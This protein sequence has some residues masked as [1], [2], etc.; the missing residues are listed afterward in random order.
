MALSM[1]QASIPQF[2]AMLTNLSAILKKAE[3]HA[4]AHKID[5]KVFMEARL[6]PDMLPLT[7]QVQIAC[8]QPKNGFA[9]LAGIEPPKYEDKEASFA[10]LYERIAKTIAFI[11]TIKPEQ[12]DGSEKKEIK[13]SIFE[14][15]F[16]FVGD[17]YLLSWII[18]NFYFHVATAH[19]I[20]RHNG[21]PI[22]KNDYLGR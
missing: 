4:T 17:Q 12:I 5:P 20:L 15:N 2:K 10:E 3:E 14:W 6:F 19:D 9:R 22:G 16:E 21:V 18:P 11:D 1:Y 8:D 13:F 7:K